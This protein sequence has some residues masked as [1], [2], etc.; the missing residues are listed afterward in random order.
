MLVAKGTAPA[1]IASTTR[2][3]PGAATEKGIVPLKVEWRLQWTWL[4][5]ENEDILR[6]AAEKFT[7]AG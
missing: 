6:L 1:L 2:V 7:V 3:S 5:H 4:R